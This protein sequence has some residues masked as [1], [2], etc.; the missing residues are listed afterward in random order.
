MTALEIATEALGSISR[1]SC[2]RGCQEAKLVALAAL[3]RISGAAWPGLMAGFAP[4][5]T[6]HTTTNTGDTGGPSLDIP[7]GSV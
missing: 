2:C 5:A 1:N 3:S 7:K 6:D 4:A